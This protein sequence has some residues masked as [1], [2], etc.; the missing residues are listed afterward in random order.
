[1]ST[2]DHAVPPSTDDVDRKNCWCTNL[3]SLKSISTVG[4]TNTSKAASVLTQHTR[5][6]NAAHSNANYRF[7]SNTTIQRGRKEYFQSGDGSKFVTKR[8][9]A[10]KRS[11]S[12]SDEDRPSQKES[13]PASDGY[14]EFARR[15]DN[16]ERGIAIA[17]FSQCVLRLFLESSFLYLQY[18][19]FDFHVPELYKCHRWPCPNTVRL[20]FGL[21]RLFTCTLSKILSLLCN[22][23]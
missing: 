13:E 19:I 3:P 16:I 18:R 20:S 2:C 6:T 9:T 17:Y 22:D 10:T 12:M 8:S 7:F 14:I 5:V 21:I 23:G 11:N 4:R 1:M 15:I